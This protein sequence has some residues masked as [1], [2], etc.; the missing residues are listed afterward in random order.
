MLCHVPS[1][2]LVPGTYYVSLWI[3][4][5]PRL[6]DSVQRVAKVEV[7]RQ[8]VYGTG[9]LPG[10]SHGF[11]LSQAEWRIEPVETASEHECAMMAASD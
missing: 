3:A 6:V 8:D 1:F 10:D 2:P 9:S 7:L 4:S 5:F 11:F